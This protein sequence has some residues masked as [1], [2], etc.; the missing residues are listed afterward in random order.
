MLIWE[1]NRPFFAMHRQRGSCIWLSFGLDYVDDVPVKEENFVICLEQNETA[2][3]AT[4]DKNRSFG[5]I[6]R[7]MID[8]LL[9]MLNNAVRTKSDLDFIEYVKTNKSSA[10]YFTYILT[11]P[12]EW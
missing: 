10:A 6:H 1:A 9:E 3:R 11:E 12:D 7:S 8:R 2:W 5:I 4:L